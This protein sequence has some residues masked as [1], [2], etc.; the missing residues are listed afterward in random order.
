MQS[1]ITLFQIKKC[2]LYFIFALTIASPFTAWVEV[3]SVIEALN[4]NALI[5]K[6]HSFSPNLIL[7]VPIF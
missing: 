4:N 7:H 5:F 6:E 3:S 2:T 1:L